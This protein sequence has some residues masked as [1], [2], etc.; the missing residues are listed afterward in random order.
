MRS[1][2]KS[3]KEVRLL[4]VKAPLKSP[5]SHRNQSHHREPE[6]SGGWGDHQHATSAPQTVAL[7]LPVVALLSGSTVPA[8]CALL[9]KMTHHSCGQLF[10]SPGGP[11]V[12]LCLMMSWER[13]FLL[14][15]GLVIGRKWSLRKEK[16]A[17]TDSYRRAAAP[18][19]CERDSRRGAHKNLKLSLI[20]WHSSQRLNCILFIWQL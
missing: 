17:G 4:P 1:A 20:Y 14:L 5:V 12:R 7:I 11:A 6:P 2:T 18:E 13:S 15:F 19:L 16:K 8:V 9:P 3:R 10:F